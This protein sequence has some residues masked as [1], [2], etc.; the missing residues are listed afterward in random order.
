MELIGQVTA[1]FR[2]KD[3]GEI[4]KIKKAEN[5]I[6]DRFLEDLIVGSSQLGDQLFV[7]DIN[8]GKQRRDWGSQISGGRAGND[9]SGVPNPQ[10]TQNAEPGIHL[11]ECIQR[12]DAPASDY[13]INIAGVA[14]NYVTISGGYANNVMAVVWFETPCIQ[15]TTETLDLYYRIQF[16]FDQNWET[17]TLGSDEA[18]NINGWEAYQWFRYVTDATNA[19]LLE[20][21]I[22]YHGF[23]MMPKVNYR[24]LFTEN[25]SSQ[26]ADQTIA[27]FN[28]YLD[29][30]NPLYYRKGTRVTF[31]ITEAVG[32][33]FTHVGPRIDALRHK[34][35]QNGE[36]PLQSVFGHR[37]T[38]DTPFYNAANA[39][40][41]LG[42]VAVNADAY[43]YPN[44]FAKWFKV[45]IEDAGLVGVG[46]YKFRFRNHFGVVGNTFENTE[47]CRLA[48]TFFES[49]YMNDGFAICRD[50]KDT[51]STNVDAGASTFPYKY[52]SNLDYIWIW[53][54]EICV[55]NL[56]TCEGIPF[57]NTTIIGTDLIP[58]F[59]VEDISQ[60][61]HDTSDNIYVACKNTGL[62][63]LNA[64]LD[65]LDVIDNTVTG[66]AGTLGCQGVAIGNAGRI[67]AFFDHA[68]TP[69][70]YYSDDSGVSWTP[71]G[72]VHAPI[73]SGLLVNSVH[74]DRNDAGGKVGIGYYNNTTTDDR[75]LDIV[76][77]DHAITT[78]IQGPTAVGF[79]RNN[80]AIAAYGQFAY[81][82]GHNY[83]LAFAWG[84]S[85][86]DGLWASVNRRTTYNDIVQPCFMTFG[87][88][89]VVGDSRAQDLDGSYC[90]YLNWV[91]D[92]SGTDAIIYA[93]HNGENAGQASQ[94]H[95][96][97]LMESDGT[98]I[99]YVWGNNL[100]NEH[101]MD[102]DGPFIHIEDGVWLCIRDFNSPSVSNKDNVT[103]FWLL[104]AQLPTD[105][106]ELDSNPG[107]NKIMFPS[108]GWN[109]TAWERDHP[110]VKTIH[111]AAEE[112][113]YGITMAFDDDSGTNIFVDTDFYSFG[114]G[115][116]IWLDGSTSFE[117]EYHMYTKPSYISREIEAPTLPASTKVPNNIINFQTDQISDFQDVLG[118]DCGGGLG[119]LEGTGT[120]AIDDYNS[121]A[122]SL[123]PAIDGSLLSF[124]PNNTY[125]PGTEVNNVQGWVEWAVDHTVGAKTQ[126]YVG[127]SSSAQIGE[128]LDET[129]I[130]H[131]IHM[132]TEGYLPGD[133]SV[134]QA[135]VVEGGIERATVDNLP[136]D[137][138]RFR[139]ALLTNSRMLYQYYTPEL[140]WQELYITPLGTTTIQNYYLDVAAAPDSNYGL[141]DLT[142]NYLDT[143]NPDYYLY[144]GNGLDV[145]LFDD[146]FYAV[147][148]D[149]ITVIIDGTESVNVGAN[150]SA[151]VL[152]ANSYSIFPFSG[153]IRYSASDV[154]KTV[155]AKYTTIAHS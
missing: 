153:V 32:W 18:E 4:T 135:R 134:M 28:N 73:T 78:A 13:T 17:W 121:G 3:T 27:N 129:T 141:E 148:P 137:T 48:A 109:G 130:E 33:F 16:K 24:K 93:S 104:M 111:A 60:V 21:A 29:I 2:D 26:N 59:L 102:G 22:N 138:V 54:D 74:A 119:S 30:S 6:Q 34:I 132:D 86:D 116:G 1:V 127:V 150:D 67:W 55:W 114:I 37:D 105:M 128:P 115:D 142:F 110:G 84:C 52:K 10:R 57:D 62:Y 81:Q 53:K 51:W 76:W 42:T 144:L 154:G 118:L 120:A 64:A 20:Q 61:T 123:N 133:N 12:F 5:H 83:Y 68:T 92:A 82:D 80:E 25:Y 139:I 155:E 99:E 75:Q 143:S 147:D 36:S 91:K 106:S 56:E 9:I 100:G 72:L 19:H 113:L 66:L 126:W 7:N 79:F 122:R 112:L 152:N 94:G 70:L 145:G 131:A 14:Q 31:P 97:C 23:G 41:G 98:T 149:F 71:C 88:A 96:I 89:T 85:P 117:F 58:R 46:T 87:S 43:T 77:W 47:R 63:I 50:D 40:T 35:L 44:P 69:D 8:P 15:T 38:S 136:V 124:L 90:M 151:S 95:C 49:A 108:Y 45:E 101:Y 140:G 125:I 39:Q 65:N 11:Y 107:L 103:N 146:D